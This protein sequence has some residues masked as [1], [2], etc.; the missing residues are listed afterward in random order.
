MQ[1]QSEDA[2]KHVDTW[3]A[4]SFRHVRDN[5]KDRQ[6]REAPWCLNLQMRF[7][8]IKKT[9]IFSFIITE[10]GIMMQVSHPIQTVYVYVHIY[11]K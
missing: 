11:N 4:R 1:A 6:A 3:R 5:K 8:E 9:Q 2:A 10:R 7:T